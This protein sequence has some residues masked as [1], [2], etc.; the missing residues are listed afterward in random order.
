MFLNKHLFWRVQDSVPK[1]D[2]T[3]ATHPISDLGK[4]KDRGSEAIRESGFWGSP[5]EEAAS[6]PFSKGFHVE[7]LSTVL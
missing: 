6:F 7:H 4:T 3:T 2:Q 1:Y 5:G